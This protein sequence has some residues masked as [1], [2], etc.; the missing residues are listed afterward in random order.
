MSQA[1][2]TLQRAHTDDIVGIAGM[3]IS[4]EDVTH[5][6]DIV[7]ALGADIKTIGVNNSR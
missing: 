3:D 5:I 4:P 1:R 2:I 6:D 7:D